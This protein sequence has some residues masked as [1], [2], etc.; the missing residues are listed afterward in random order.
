MK[1]KRAYRDNFRPCFKELF[2]L[3]FGNSYMVSQDKDRIPDFT[4][5]YSDIL[6]IL[7]QVQQGAALKLREQGTEVSPANP[8]AWS[9]TNILFGCI[10]LKGFLD[11]RTA[12]SFVGVEVSQ[13]E[14]FKSEN[15]SGVRF[16]QKKQVYVY[17]PAHSEREK[18]GR[19]HTAAKDIHSSRRTWKIV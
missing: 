7:S 16:S 10:L 15:L 6:S 1:G 14:S 8:D 13:V 4:G 17:I 19:T 12:A 3:F 9:G 18:K 5:E 2:F 11:K